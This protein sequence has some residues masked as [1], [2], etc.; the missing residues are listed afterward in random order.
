MLA[1]LLATLG[2]PA[3]ARAAEATTPAESIGPQLL[4]GAD[5]GVMGFYPLVAARAGVGYRLRFPLSVAAL[6]EV[7]HAS[8][9]GILGGP[10]VTIDGVFPHV[11]VSTAVV[12]AGAFRRLAVRLFTGPA[13]TN[14]QVSEAGQSA[15]H[16]QVRLGVGSSVSYSIVTLGWRY[17]T[18]PAQVCQSSNGQQVCRV[19]GEFQITLGVLVDVLSLFGS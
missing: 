11:M 1:P 4:I 8:G 12:R 15:N 10:T 13:F 3:A 18:P 2:Q 7:H 19:G 6:V 5:V 9:R 17:F 14:T 16:R